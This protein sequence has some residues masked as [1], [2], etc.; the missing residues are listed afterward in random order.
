MRAKLFT[1]LAALS[2]L[3]LLTAAALTVR[4]LW[5]EDEVTW[6]RI[7]GDRLTDEADTV[8]LHKGWLVV[9]S[10]R[11]RYFEKQRFDNVRSW[12]PLGVPGWT[13]TSS[14]AGE[15]WW[16]R[17]GEG[18][19][20]REILSIGHERWEQG[21]EGWTRSVQTIVLPPWL[22][23]LPWLVLRALWLRGW[24]RR[25]FARRPGLCARCGYDLRAT[26]GRCP[27]CGP[28]A[29]AGPG[30]SLVAG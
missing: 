14:P 21:D 9:S 22:L 25:R 17:F 3:L 16:S 29:P 15:G 8:K 28:S 11:E 6:R 23:V 13:R 4:S 12:N 5:V 30:P 10:R 20:Q 1:A 7:D 2:L 18:P 26:P 27:E 19:R 24:W